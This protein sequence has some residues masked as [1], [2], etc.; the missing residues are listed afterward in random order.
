MVA[1]WPPSAR[2]VVVMVVGVFVVVVVVVGI[3]VVVV[4]VVGH[5]GRDGRSGCRGCCPAMILLLLLLLVLPQ[6]QLTLQSQ[7]LLGRS[8]VSHARTQTHMQRE[9]RLRPHN[10]AGQRRTLTLL[11]V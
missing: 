9:V 8:C 2:V 4:V 6:S 3:V 11:D 1:W 5:G 7:A 10:P